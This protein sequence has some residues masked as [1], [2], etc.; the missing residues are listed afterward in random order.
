MKLKNCVFATLGVLGTLAFSTAANAAF[1]SCVN[2]PADAGE[3][4]NINNKVTGLKV[5]SPNCQILLPLAFAGN[6]AGGDSDLS[7][8]N[9]L[10]PGFF[11]VTSWLADGK[12]DGLGDNAGGT[13]TSSLFSFDASGNNSSGSFTFVNAGGITGITNIMFVFKDGQDTNL[14][15]YLMAGT[16]GT[17]STPFVDP[18][19]DFSNPNNGNGPTSK[20]TSH[21]SVFYTV[22]PRVPPV[23]L[24]EPGSL[25]LLG[26]GLLGLGAARWRRR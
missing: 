13:D 25:A 1:Q 17:Y 10:S 15:G 11:G 20:G 23:L 12:W 2:G 9:A 19:F 6:P 22:D 8:I 18:P 24:P 21:I 26:L 14:V 4:Y 3:D 16:L 7:A 5:A